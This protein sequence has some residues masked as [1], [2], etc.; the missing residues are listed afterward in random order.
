MSN[1]IDSGGDAPHL[2]TNHDQGHQDL[3]NSDLKNS[4]LENSQLRGVSRFKTPLTIGF[5]LLALVLACHRGHARGRR[6][7]CRFHRS[8][9]LVPTASKGAAR[10]VL[11]RRRR[12]R[13]Q[14]R[15]L[16]I[17][18][19]ALSRAARWRMGRC[20]RRS[21]DHRTEP[22]RPNHGV[23]VPRLS[24]ADHPL[25]HAG[26]HDPASAVAAA[27]QHISCRAPA[28]RPRCPAARG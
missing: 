1:W 14:R 8:R 3:E 2:C 23:A 7:L 26:Q 21:R 11:L 17:R 27:A 10:A 15:R 28:A 12:H 18:Q 9:S 16:A 5:A 13:G 4:D 6:P 19:R 20:A 25:L 24:R 22:G